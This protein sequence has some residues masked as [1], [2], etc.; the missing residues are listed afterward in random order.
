M[1][2]PSINGISVIAPAPTTTL[3]LT[4]IPTF[5]QSRRSTLSLA[6]HSV[7]PSRHPTPIEVIC[8]LVCHDLAG[9]EWVAQL[10]FFPGREDDAALDAQRC[11]QLIQQSIGAPLPIQALYQPR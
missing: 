4:L 10:P 6:K 8:V 9:G 3:A 7:P 1:H 5:T 11:S 2:V